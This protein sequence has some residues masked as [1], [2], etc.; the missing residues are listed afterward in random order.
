MKQELAGL[1]KSWGQGGLDKEAM[2]KIKQAIYKLYNS[3]D[4]I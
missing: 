3:K 4:N 2:E 1:T